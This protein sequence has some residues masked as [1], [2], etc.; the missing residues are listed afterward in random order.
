M[1]LQQSNSKRCN[2]S[3]FNGCNFIIIVTYYVFP[4]INDYLLQLW[5]FERKRSF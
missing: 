4:Y 2:I 5:T 1:Q 3:L